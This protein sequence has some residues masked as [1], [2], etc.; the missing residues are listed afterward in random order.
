MSTEER[1]WTS[2]SGCVKKEGIANEQKFL[3][4]AFRPCDRIYVKGMSDKEVMEKLTLA[5][6]NVA[7]NQANP[8]NAIRSAISALEILERDVDA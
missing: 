1:E 5:I 3:V 2:L 7:S 8:R 6:Y 4:M